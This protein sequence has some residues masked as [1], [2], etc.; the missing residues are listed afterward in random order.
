MSARE[1]ETLWSYLS[2]LHWLKRLFLPRV[3]DRASHPS[4]GS[5][6]ELLW[7][8]L[9][10]RS[11]PFYLFY[12][13]GIADFLQSDFYYRHRALYENNLLTRDAF[14]SPQ[15]DTL[16]DILDLLLHETNYLKH[17]EQAEEIMINLFRSSDL[18]S[19]HFVLVRLIRRGF[20]NVLTPFSQFKCLLAEEQPKLLLK[21]L[22]FCEFREGLGL[23]FPQKIALEQLWRLVQRRELADAAVFRRD[24]FQKI[25]AHP[26][27]EELVLACS[28]LEEEGLLNRKEI[29]LSY[30]DALM[31]QNDPVTYAGAL[32]AVHR[33]ERLSLCQILGF[34]RFFLRGFELTELPLDSLR[35]TLKTT[36]P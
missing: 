28:L 25:Q 24:F 4:Q 21:M 30:F 11:F 22:C 36:C 17:R 5:L 31:S 19:F 12:Y 34:P 10:L 14:S 2:R 29:G 15:W 1:L 7:S 18:S 6:Q 27:L 20:I 13:Q 26:R 35:K 3:I 16:S 23:S 9:Q 32:I 8:I 33:N